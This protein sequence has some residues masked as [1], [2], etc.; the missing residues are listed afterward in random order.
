VFGT[1]KSSIPTVDPVAAVIKAQA[2]LIRDSPRAVLE[3]EDP[4][5]RA[6]PKSTHLSGGEFSNRGFA[7]INATAMMGTPYSR[8]V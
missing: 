1:G 6:L 5:I 3:D 2:T 4:N 8:G 7:D